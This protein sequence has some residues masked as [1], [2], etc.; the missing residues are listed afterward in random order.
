MVV[1]AA[2]SAQWSCPH[3]LGHA[4]SCLTDYF[5]LVTESSAWPAELRCWARP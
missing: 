2:I 3:S 5:I 1:W 4:V